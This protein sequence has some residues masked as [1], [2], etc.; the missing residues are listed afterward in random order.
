MNKKTLNLYRALISVLFVLA[1][2]CAA[3]V[4]VLAAIL[5]KD[6]LWLVI[7]SAVVAVLVLALWIWLL[8]ICSQLAKSA[9]SE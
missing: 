1:F 2:L 6:A 8:A 7:A 5:L 3:A 4:A 9:A